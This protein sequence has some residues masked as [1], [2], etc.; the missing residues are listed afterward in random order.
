MAWDIWK[1]RLK[2]LIVLASLKIYDILFHMFLGACLN[3]GN[4]H[5]CD[6]VKIFTPGENCKCRCTAP[7]LLTKRQRTSLNLIS[8]QCKTSILK[9][10]LVQLH[11]CKRKGRNRQGLGMDPVIKG[12]SWELLYISKILI[13]GK[14]LPRLVK[15]G[16]CGNKIAM[17]F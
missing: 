9:V 10:W 7:M 16:K 15:L 2:N 3:R 5:P 1:V 13:C 8:H 4:L 6:Y 12:P 17:L 11:Q 14:K